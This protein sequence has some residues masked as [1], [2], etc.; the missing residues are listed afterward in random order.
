MPLSRLELQRINQL[1]EQLEILYNKRHSFE[2]DITISASTNEKFELRQRLK[3][4]VLPSLRS[5]EQ[6][7]AQL[8]ARAVEPAQ[9]PEPEARALVEDV[10]VALVS[11]MRAITGEQ[12]EELRDLL[13]DIRAKLDDPGKAAAAKLKVV[14]PLI[15]LIA[16]YELEVDTESFVIQ[17]WHRIINLFRSAVPHSPL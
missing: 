14:L 13:T 8:L 16:S 6:E 15:P 10:H 2:T 5:T 17:I 7:Y 12:S 11:H 4:E 9:L 3:R 1:E